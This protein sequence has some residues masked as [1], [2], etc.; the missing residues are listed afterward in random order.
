MRPLETLQSKKHCRSLPM[1]GAC[2][3]TFV[4]LFLCF[5]V[6]FNK[7]FASFLFDIHFM[8]SEPAGCVLI[9]ACVSVCL[10]PCACC[11]DRCTDG[12]FLQ[13]CWFWCLVQVEGEGVGEG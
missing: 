3:L 5:S 1:F 2:P 12:Y 11:T 10:C 7:F 4:Y 6:A 9:T 8:R 13:L